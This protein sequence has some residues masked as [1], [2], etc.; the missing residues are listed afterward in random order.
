M[1]RPGRYERK[2]IVR[3]KNLIVRI[4]ASPLCFSGHRLRF[5]LRRGHYT[6]KKKK[7]ITRIHRHI[8]TCME[9]HGRA[10]CLRACCDARLVEGVC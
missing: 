9:T 2:Q 4:G 5:A 3:E 10:R 7:N 8:C 6:L 1:R